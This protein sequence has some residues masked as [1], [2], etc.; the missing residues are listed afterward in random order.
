MPSSDI[1][2][3]TLFSPATIVARITG[4][5]V[6]V[7]ARC[8]AAVAYID[9]HVYGIST[10]VIMESPCS[11]FSITQIQ[12]ICEGICQRRD[13]KLVGKRRTQGVL[14]Y[15]RTL[16]PSGHQLP[17]LAT[18]FCHHFSPDR[19]STRASLSVVSHIFQCS[20]LH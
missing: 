19:P 9:W 2:I 1:R 8:F 17:R 14:L 5:D 7:D 6:D 4:I 13:V 18:S 16:C 15:R 20:V 10:S 3:P 11:H 12:Y